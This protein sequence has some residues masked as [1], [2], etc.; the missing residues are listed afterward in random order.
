MSDN[1]TEKFPEGVV[2]SFKET[3]FRRQMKG[4]CVCT[5]LCLCVCVC[6]GCQAHPLGSGPLPG[7]WLMMVVGTVG[8]SRARNVDP[9]FNHCAPDSRVLTVSM[10][11]LLRRRA[12]SVP[13]EFQAIS[14]GAGII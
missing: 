10:F 2:Q 4:V 7:K 14:V 13:R 11:R 8:W 5:C 1:A 3:F 12:D 6:A 9:D